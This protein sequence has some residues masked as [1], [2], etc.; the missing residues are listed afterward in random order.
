MPLSPR[1][2]PVRAVRILWTAAVLIVLGQLAVG[3]A[4]DRAPMWVRFP[5]GEKAVS[6][7]ARLGDRPFVALFGSSRFRNLDLTSMV[8]E[9]E[10]TLEGEGPT[11]VQ[12]SVLAG[13]PIVAEFL[14]DAMLS[15]G[16]RPGLAV[17][18][19]SP[20]TLSAPAHWIGDHV[21]RFL[22]APQLL[23]HLAEIHARGQLKRT[24]AKRLN[25]V[26]FYRFE[27]L[28]WITHERP[29]YLRVPPPD[30]PATVVSP[31]PNL[32]ASPGPGFRFVSVEGEESAKTASGL[33]RMRKWLDGYAVGG[34]ETQAL[35]ML[36][37]RCHAEGIPL[38]LIGVPVGSGQRSLYEGEVETR[39]REFLD[40]LLR[41]SG[42]PFLDFRDA[43]PDALF[44]D[45]HH[46]SPEG[47]RVFGVLL[48]REAIAPAWRDAERA[49]APARVAS[50]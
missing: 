25:A 8:A 12:A 1:P 5:Q 29:P 16:A 22:T 49:T 42:V 17:L 9:L 15:R 31:T 40:P 35:T 20:E 26:S 44:V 4:L 36:V 7:A 13:D 37:A 10:R 14:L 48:A 32:N 28:R 34:A 46:L 23:R 11:L 2:H 21:T 41:E 39:F 47:G 50:R 19:L 43:V 45:N 18:E 24:L 27:L 33:R 3:S 30:A 38:L 6:S